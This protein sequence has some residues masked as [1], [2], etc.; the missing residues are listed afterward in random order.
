MRSV[1]SPSSVGSGH[2]DSSRKE[3]DAAAAPGNISS[4][5][6]AK[7]PQTYS[8]YLTLTLFE[9]WRATHTLKRSQPFGKYRASVVPQG[10]KEVETDAV[11]SVCLSRSLEVYYLY[12]S[13]L[14]TWTGTPF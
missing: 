3:V 7:V 10:R 8:R 2:S 13:T 11:V 9:K 1:T 12:L 14:R 4:K 5:D 6:H